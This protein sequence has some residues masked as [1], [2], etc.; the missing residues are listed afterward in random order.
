MVEDAELATCYALLDKQMSNIVRAL[1]EILL[2]HRD[3][4]LA[5]L[6]AEPTDPAIL[7][8]RHLV[9]EK[10]EEALAK[11]QTV[12]DLVGVSGD[13]EPRNAAVGGPAV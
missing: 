10:V 5:F 4:P 12:Q 6:S 1:E 7:G 13:A 11:M 8:A 9:R 3:G 2:Q